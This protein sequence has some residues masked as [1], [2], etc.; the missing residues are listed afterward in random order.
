MLAHY[1]S[2]EAQ[3]ATLGYDI[4]GV[5]YK[6][7]SLALQ[8]RLGFVSRAPRWATAHKFPAEKATSV[9]RDIEI[10]VGRAARERL[11]P[12]CDLG[13][14]LLLEKLLNKGKSG[15]EV[16][17]LTGLRT[18][19]YVRTKAKGHTG[20]IEGDQLVQDVLTEHETFANHFRHVCGQV[21]DELET[22]ENFL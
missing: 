8:Q 15:D 19:Q 9:L 6:V 1:R 5:V 11:R 7:D 16:G 2:I 12:P 4:D 17:K 10:Q 22:V 21:S 3:R 20:G 14:V 13:P 18:V